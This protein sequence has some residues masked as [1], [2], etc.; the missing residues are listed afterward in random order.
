LIALYFASPYLL[1]FLVSIVYIIYNRLPK[2]VHLS[3]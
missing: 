3:V 2:N 1:S